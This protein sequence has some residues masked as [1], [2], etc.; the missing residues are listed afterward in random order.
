MT[1]GFLYLGWED[2][3]TNYFWQF[4]RRTKSEGVEIIFSVLVIL[5]WQ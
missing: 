1:L 4:R 2:G 3:A 5:N